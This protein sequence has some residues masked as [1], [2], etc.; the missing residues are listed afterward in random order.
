MT[1]SL[2]TGHYELGL[3]TGEGPSTRMKLVPFFLR[4]FTY[5]C[6]RSVIG[7]S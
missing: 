6:L 3:K 4:L 2:E 7:E 1:G 5:L